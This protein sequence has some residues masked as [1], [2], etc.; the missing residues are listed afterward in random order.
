VTFVRA[1]R[2]AVTRSVPPARG[3]ALLYHRVADLDTD[4]QLL[5]VSP[6][7]FADHLAILRRSYVSVSLSDLR[8]RTVK[9][10]SKI[11]SIAVTFDD[12]YADNLHVAVPLLEAAAVPATIFVVTG[13]IGNPAQFWWDEVGGV[14]LQAPELPEELAIR[15]GME[16]YRRTIPRMV[17]EADPCWNVLS[18]DPPTPLQR[19]YQELCELIRPLSATA[20][21]DA[22]AQ[23]REWANTDP[24]ARSE[25]RTL[26]GDEVAVLAGNGLIEVGSH[27]MTHPVLSKQS[28]SVQR[29]EIN[30]SKQIL[31]DLVSSPVRSF[32][33]PFGGHADYTK[34]TVRLV[35]EAAFTQACSN[36]PGTVGFTTNPLEIPRMLVRN[37]TGDEFER[38][39]SEEFNA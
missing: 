14:L 15:V 10:P 7:N 19:I 13:Q 2:D 18:E 8:P 32:S 34:Q 24:T 5:A 26:T 30:G 6:R 31:E 17:R 39:L 23:L 3:I 27:T 33:Y 1:I 29:Q 11:R 36:F 28:T 16:W 9:A 12:G 20:R 25:N 37:W 21:S 35:S 22:L 38:R 4:P